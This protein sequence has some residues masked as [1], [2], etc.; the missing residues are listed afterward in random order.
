MLKSAT[1]RRLAA[2]VMAKAYDEILRAQVLEGI[3]GVTPGSWSQR[4][5]PKLREAAATLGLSMSSPW[6]KSDGSYALYKAVKNSLKRKF[7]GDDDKVEEMLNWIVGGATRKQG[8]GYMTGRYTVKDFTRE[9][10]EGNPAP[11]MTNA[12]RIL[13]DHAAH[14]AVNENRNDKAQRRTFEDGTQVLQD[15]IEVGFDGMTQQVESETAFSNNFGQMLDQLRG[16]AKKKFDAWVIETAED[17]LAPAKARLLKFYVENHERADDNMLKLAEL[18]HKE[19][20]GEI[21]VDR[22]TAK[23]TASRWPTIFKELAPHLKGDMPRVMDDVDISVALGYS[24]GG[25][26]ASQKREVREAKA[27]LLWAA[28]RRLFNV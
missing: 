28:V 4:N 20:L 11:G 21:D 7:K 1:L 16:P 3:A 13:T 15:G 24:G 17:H 18:Y 9:L 12:V 14:K 25:R 23:T 8:A 22:Q 6:I 19:V 26:L 5:P 27:R 2:D 10:A